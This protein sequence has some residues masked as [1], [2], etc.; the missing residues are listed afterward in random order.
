MSCS[1]ELSAAEACVAS[2]PG[3]CSCISSPFSDF[4]IE[5]QTAY[6]KTLAFESPGSEMFCARSLF[7]VCDLMDASSCCCN[8]EVNAYTRC[9]Y[10]KELATT[11]AVSNCAYNCG[12][13]SDSDGEGGGGNTGL[14]IA[15]SV[16]VLFFCC[17][18]SYCWYR[19]RR[20][21]SGRDEK[22][23]SI[24]TWCI[25]IFESTVVL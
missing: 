14:I 9:A 17:L 22:Q 23:V 21:Q 13:E 7:Y 11:F 20:R 15:S 25:Y 24:F 18:F 12:G 5:V 10:E 16:S 4:V 6:R 19:R 1:S 8:A 2:D 3:S